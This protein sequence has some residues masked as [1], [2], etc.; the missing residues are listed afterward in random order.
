[1][2]MKGHRK[3]NNARRPWPRKEI[4]AHTEGNCP[5]CPRTVKNVEIHIERKHKY[6]KPKPIKGRVHG[7]KFV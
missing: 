6:A 3:W 1:M 4:Q 7:A 5:F 2:E